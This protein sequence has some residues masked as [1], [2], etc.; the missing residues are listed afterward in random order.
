ML[1]IEKKKYPVY[2]KSEQAGEARHVCD[3]RLALSLSSDRRDVDN[4]CRCVYLKKTYRG[5][6][7]ACDI[8]EG[9][10]VLIGDERVRVISVAQDGAERLLHLESV[11]IIDTGYMELGE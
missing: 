3:T 11:Q 9:D 5:M 10:I 1:E 4:D 8:K 6:C 2:R 7:D